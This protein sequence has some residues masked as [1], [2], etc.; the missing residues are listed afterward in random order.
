MS[1]QPFWII[2]IGAQKK[3]KNIKGRNKKNLKTTYYVNGPIVDQRPRQRPDLR[4]QK[5]PKKNLKT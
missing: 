4:I 5:E 1:T 3:L 2:F